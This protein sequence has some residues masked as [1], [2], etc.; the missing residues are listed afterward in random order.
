VKTSW[1]EGRLIANAS[2][3]A[4]RYDRLQTQV[5]QA[6]LGGTVI[7]LTPDAQGVGGEIELAAK[8]VEP[9]LIRVG[10]SLLEA[11]ITSDLTAVNLATGAPTNLRGSRLPR[12]PQFTLAAT[13]E[14][15]FT[16]GPGRITPRLEVQHSGAQDFDLFN[17]AAARQDAYTLWN[18]SVDLA[19]PDDR[20][21]LQ[22]F[23][24]NITDEAYRV[25]SV[26]ATGPGGVGVVDFLGTP[27]T[28]GAR[29]GV[30]F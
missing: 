8:P 22:L 4:Y 19:A 12:A 3:F 23:A 13:A 10:L 15:A 26:A 9:A 30:R 2:A 5:N 28:W 1:L 6:S 20:V 21:M 25:A 11:E 17:N 24:K 27:R 14:Y 29:V 7:V 16:V 18:A